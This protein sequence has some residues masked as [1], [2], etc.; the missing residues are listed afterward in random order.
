MRYYVKSGNVPH[1]RKWN[2]RTIRSTLLDIFAFSIPL[3]IW[4]LA[5]FIRVFIFGGVI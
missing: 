5:N 2:I 3:I 4:G 1:V